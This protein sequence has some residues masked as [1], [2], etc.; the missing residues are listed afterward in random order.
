MR[1]THWTYTCVYNTIM[2]QHAGPTTCYSP[3]QHY[4]TVIY[5][6]GVCAATYYQ[7][8]FINTFLYVYYLSSSSKEICFS[9]TSFEH[10]FYVHWCQNT[11]GKANLFMK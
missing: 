11:G 5:V 7:I 6:D 4:L 3:G 10:F 1:V 2:C 8:M 9:V